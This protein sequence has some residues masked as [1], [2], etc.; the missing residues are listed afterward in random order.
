MRDLFRLPATPPLLFY[1]YVRKAWLIS[2]VNSYFIVFLLLFCIEYLPGLDQVQYSLREGMARYY[3]S[4]K[5][6]GG[7]RLNSGRE[8][9]LSCLLHQSP[10]FNNNVYLFV[11]LTTFGLLL[12]LDWLVHYVDCPNF[13]PLIVIYRRVNFVYHYLGCTSISRPL[14]YPFRSMRLNLGMEKL[15]LR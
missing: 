10:N 1:S 12:N 13:Y 8:G 15:K 5:V 11:G 7:A 6:S 9:T 3:N 4:F 14:S 2:Y